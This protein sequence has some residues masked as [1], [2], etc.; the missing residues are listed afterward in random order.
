M[1]LSEYMPPESTELLEDNDFERF[2]HERATFIQRGFINDPVVNGDDL[3]WETDRMGVHRWYLLPWFGDRALSDWYV[4]VMD[5]VTHTGKHT[6]QGGLVIYVLEGSGYTVID[7]V[8]H[9]W[10]AG[11][12][13]LL[14]V[15]PGG[16]EHQHFNRHE[17]DRCRWMALIYR[18]AWNYVA[19][20]VTQQDNDPR[21]MAR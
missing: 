10:E 3:A 16:V 17:G 5:I 20:E 12:L 8:R 4:F 11:D 13:I 14:P 1:D 6:H 18:P 15:K 19:A 21:W 7:G 2:M 9:D